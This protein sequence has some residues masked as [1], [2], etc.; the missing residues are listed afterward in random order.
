[1]LGRFSNRVIGITGAYGGFGREMVQRITTEQGRVVAI[2]RD[3]KK[4]DLLCNEFECECIKADLSTDEGQDMVIEGLIKFKADSLINNAGVFKENTWIE[5][6]DKY[7]NKT[8]EPFTR[9]IYDM[10]MNINLKSPLFLS[11]GIAKHWIES[12]VAGNIVNISSCAS[13]SP[14]LGH[15]VYGLSKSGMDYITKHM[16]LELSPY[17]IQVNSVNATII[18]SEMGT[19]P[20]GYWG[21]DYRKK[22]A[23]DR[24]PIGRF[25]Y[26]EEVVSVV[27]YLLSNEA[28]FLVGQNIIL[29]GGLTCGSSNVDQKVFIEK[30]FNAL[31]DKIEALENQIKELTK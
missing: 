22:W 18:E 24:L 13:K 11:Q 14:L 23:F 19:G 16:A 27:C 12:K 31:Q 20:R 10:I 3:K 21:N 17:D 9:D 15:T 25:G 4:L 7:D 30:D 8:V 26:V 2:G 29:D 28:R 5:K 1:M 6:E